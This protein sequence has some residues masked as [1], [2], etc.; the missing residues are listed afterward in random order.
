MSTKDIPRVQK[1]KMNI[2][3]AKASFGLCAKSSSLIFFIPEKGR[4]RFTVL[5]M[6]Q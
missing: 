1:L 5:S 3:R 2:S 4:L 6:P